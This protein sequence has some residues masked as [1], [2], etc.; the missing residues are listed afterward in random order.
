VPVLFYCLVMAFLH[1]DKS[2]GRHESVTYV[3]KADDL[4]NEAL[5]DCMTV[6]DRRV[7]GFPLK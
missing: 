1:S 7:P 3:S 6:N 4:L 2:S 5:K